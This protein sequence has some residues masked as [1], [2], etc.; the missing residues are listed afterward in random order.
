[1]VF[2]KALVALCGVALLG[3][4]AAITADAE[5]PAPA[6]AVPLGSLT[7][8]VGAETIFT[9]YSAPHTDTYVVGRISGSDQVV[10]FECFSPWLH[11]RTVNGVGGDHYSDT[12]AWVLGGC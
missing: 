8:G 2:R 4:A 10:P 3:S 6:K 12:V 7:R 1:M 5:A 9:M 11:F